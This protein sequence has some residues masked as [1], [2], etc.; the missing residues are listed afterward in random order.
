MPLRANC[1]AVQRG[2]KGRGAAE[3]P[4]NRF[5]EWARIHEETAEQDDAAPRTVVAVQRAASIVTRNDS[6]DVPFKQ[7]INPY[8]GCEHGCV[9]CFARPSHAY[10]GLSAGLDFET[11]LFAK[12]NAPELLRRE[13]SRPGYRC[14]V[15]ALGTNTD[16]YQPIER[17]HRITRALLEIMLEFR[18]PVRIV[19]KL[20]LVE[21]D[22]DLLE[23]LARHQLAEVMFSVTSMDAELA[24]K[25]EP[26]AAAPYRRIESIRR[27]FEAGVRCGVLVAPVIPFLNDGDLEEVL[28]AAREAGARTAGYVAVRLPR[29]VKELFKE[30]LERHYPMKS[31]RIMARVRD[32]HGGREYDASW[33]RRMSG[34]GVYGS[35]LRRRFASACARFGLET[36]AR[37]NISSRRNFASPPVDRLRFSRPARCMEAPKPV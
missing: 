36:G 37:G 13:L 12:Q 7:S 23:E 9:Y 35:L 22:A 21:L 19:T 30:W 3:N 34:A 18:Q 27:I 32:L 31:E 25:L 17:R 1:N 26:R 2:F 5:E 15:I 8:L 20:A 4:Q 28:R 33:G 16:P 10:L 14:E 11:H 24:R 29:E 6:P